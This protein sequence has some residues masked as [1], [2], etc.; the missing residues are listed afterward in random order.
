[1]SSNS[2]P[3]YLVLFYGVSSGHNGA[4]LG[5]DEQDLVTLVYLV[6]NTEENKVKH[7]SMETNRHSDFPL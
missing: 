3:K 6:L 4:N 5:S 7:P 2:K 1:M